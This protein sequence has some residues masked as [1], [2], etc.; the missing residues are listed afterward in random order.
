MNFCKSLFTKSP[1]AGLAAYFLMCLTGATTA[2][3]KVEYDSQRLE[4]K[5][6]EQMANLV[7][8]KIRKAQAIQTRV[9]SGDDGALEVSPDALAEMRDAM[10]IVLSR[11][12]DQDGARADLFGRL[13]RELNDLNSYEEVLI[14][15]VDESISELKSNRASTNEQVTYVVILR[16]LLAEI[17][18]EAKVA[19]AQ[20]LIEKIRDSDL[21]ISEAA[22]KRHLLRSMSRIESPSE[23]AASILPRPTPAKEKK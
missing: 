5:N 19:Y 14:E 23:T 6:S 2:W 15:L 10:R 12:G 11:A 21:K 16:N 7:Q 22:R 18:P 13:R 9:S 20:K 3:T 1:V 4:L 17:K 8:K